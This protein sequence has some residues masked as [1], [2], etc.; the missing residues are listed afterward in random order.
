MKNYR[1]MTLEEKT[2][3]PEEG[4]SYQLPK[5][6]GALEVTPQT[7]G[8]YTAKRA[9]VPA[10]ASARNRRTHEG[11]ATLLRIP[12][13]SDFVVF[14]DDFS[15]I[16]ASNEGRTIEQYGRDKWPWWLCEGTQ[17]GEKGP[18]PV[19]KVV[20]LQTVPADNASELQP[21]TIGNITA[22]KTSHTLPTEIAGSGMRPIIQEAPIKVI[23]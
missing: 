23:S 20:E 2:I 18:K 4:S 6:P 1:I 19:K 10:S 16:D 15:E 17:L 8:L 3:I 14:A 22:S 7:P 9:I 21:W 13:T 11:Y 5:V 12:G